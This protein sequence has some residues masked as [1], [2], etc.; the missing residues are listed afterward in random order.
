M[1]NKLKCNYASILFVIILIFQ[2]FAMVYWGTQKEWFHV[3]ELFTME[4]SKA[5]GYGMRYW[6]LEGEFY[7]QEHTREEFF[8]RLTTQ[9]DDILINGGITEFAQGL[10]ERV[11]YYTLINTASIISPG[12]FTKWIGI[13]MNLILF[14]LAQLILYQVAKEMGDEKSALLTTG[15]YGFSAGGIS[16]AIYIRC[17][18]LLTLT[19]LLTVFIYLKFMKCR[20]KRQAAG[21]MVCLYL[22]AF[23]GYR[24]H[25]FGVILFGLITAVFLLYML[26]SKNF[27][28]VLW[29]MVGYGGAALAGGAIILPKLVS[30][31][32]AGVAPLFYQSVA[33]ISIETIKWNIYQMLEFAGGHL[34]VNVW[35][36]ITVCILLLLS[37]VYLGIKWWKKASERQLII[38][39]PALIAVGF[40][41]VLILGGAVTWRYASAGYPFIILYLV[42]TINE[43][44]RNV[45][46]G[47][48]LTGVFTV[49]AVAITLLSFNE[50]HISELYKGEEELQEFFEEEY[51]G[52]NGIM[53]HHDEK[54]RGENWLYEAA[55]L[56]PSDSSV[57][58]L[59]NKVL[60][61]GELCYNR[62]DEKIL[63]WLTVDYDREEALENF[64]AQT[65]YADMKLICDTGHLF[66]YECNK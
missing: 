31:F 9:E 41:I 33:N 28:K 56:W 32:K 10:L 30:F 34:F 44:C 2:L 19:A 55:S 26:I 8:A 16:T 15:I 46:R 29:L 52:I 54:G 62:T 6:D 57:L 39:M 51:H 63:L 1:K 11:F 58:I 5:R 59:Q 45:K 60:R 25:Q 23:L 14:A 17:Y 36:C 21:Y 53:V 18:M 42:L 27:R 40:Y 13:G 35:G 4:G 66:V 50:E 64:Q 65:D 37:L 48:F 43:V 24:T 7:N 61:E 12:H 3:D 49:A 20:T 47:R 22:L 38:F